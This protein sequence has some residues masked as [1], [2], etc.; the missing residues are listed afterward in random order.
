VVLGRAPAAAQ[1]DPRAIAV[2][3]GARLGV[4]YD[5]NFFL[6]E[7]DKRDD[8]REV[9]TPTLAIRLAPGRVRGELTYAPSL[10][11]SSTTDEAL[12]VFHLLNASGIVPLG[13]RLSLT[14]SEHFVRTD[15]PALADPQSLLARRR[16]VLQNVLSAGLPY[17]TETWSLAPRYTLTYNRTESDGATSVAGPGL[18]EEST[19]HVLGLDGTSELGPRNRLAASY[20]L[21]IADFKV[22]SD[23]VGQSGRLAFSREISHVTTASMQASLDH[24]DPDGGSAFNIFRADAGIRREAGPRL[25]LEARAGYQAT[26]AAGGEEMP[27]F[28]LRATYTGQW[29]RLTLA[30]DQSLQETFLGPTNVGLIRTREAS[31]ELRYE[32]SDRLAFTLRGGVAE[33][34]FLQSGATAVFGGDGERTDILTSAGLEISYKLTRLLSATA[35]YY[36]SGRESTLRGFSYDD[37]RVVFGLSFTYE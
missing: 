1:S 7:K 35:G 18:D 34:V 5:D 27:S 2:V 23:F 8:F 36:Y 24:R 16:L 11:H 30:A 3:G 37:N 28:V 19:I 9:V 32:P 12:Q 4:I 26:D 31:A 22:A 20:E 21:T 10:I 6:S 17:K 13:E 14:G 15:E 25:T 29:V 33:N